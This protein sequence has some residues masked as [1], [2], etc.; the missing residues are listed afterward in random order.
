MTLDATLP[1]SPRPIDAPT[2]MKRRSIFNVDLGLHAL[3]TIAA[4]TILVMIAGLVV[5]LL[6]QLPDRRRQFLVLPRPG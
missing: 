3:A 1:N 4:I 2:R 5:V 6:F